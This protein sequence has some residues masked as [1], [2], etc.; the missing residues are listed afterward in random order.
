MYKNYPSKS[1]PAKELKLAPSNN[2]LQ[3]ILNYSK[4]TEVV[5]T[6]KQQLIISLN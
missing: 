2:V 4:S 6:K 3:L 5:K 1:A